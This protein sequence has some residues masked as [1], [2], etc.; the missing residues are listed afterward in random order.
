VGCVGFIGAGP[1]LAEPFTER[2]GAT[3]VNG[4]GGR[5]VW[6]RYDARRKVYRLAELVGGRARLLPIASRS[7]SFDVDLGPGPQG[8]VVA[9]YSR[10]ATETELGGGGPSGP[11]AMYRAG[12]GCRIYQYSFATRK[13][14]RLRVAVGRASLFLPTVW[15]DRIAFAASMGDGTASW[16]PAPKLYVQRG[17]GAPR[18]LRGGPAAPANMNAAVD[19]PSSLDLRAST[20]LYAWN[21]LPRTA[22]CGSEE[23]KGGPLPNFALVLHR[24]GVSRRVI[25][26]GG[27]ADDGR[28]RLL[29]EGRLMS[30]T[31]LTYVARTGVPVASVRRVDVRTGRAEHADLPG[32]DSRFYSYA[33]NGTGTG[34]SSRYEEPWGAL[35][36]TTPLVFLP[37]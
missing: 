32:T 8:D 17:A 28:E 27:C 4:F 9:V 30:T 5:L 23:L 35:V 15:R 11:F 18:A 13:E 24:I 37:G 10:C 2:T 16:L 31:Q 1:A 14:R 25:A 6:S 19:G 34:L 12:L 7:V 36:T 26:H 21:S 29:G 3:H 33:E 22:A 20:L